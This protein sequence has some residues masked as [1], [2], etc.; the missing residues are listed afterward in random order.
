MMHQIFV[1][2]L[3]RNVYVVEKKFLL[4]KL[5]RLGNREHACFLEQVKASMS[6][7]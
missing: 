2:L 4:L 6:F 3:S 7:I 5:S 1:I